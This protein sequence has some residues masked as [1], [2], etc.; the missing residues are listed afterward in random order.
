MPNLTR[1]KPELDDVPAS[2]LDEFASAR[3]TKEV[4]PPPV[5]AG[6]SSERRARSTGTKVPLFKVPDDGEEVIIRF[7]DDMPFAPLWQ[8]WITVDGGKQRAFTCIDDATTQCPL[9]SRGDKA[10]PSDWFNVVELGDTPEL[11]VWK[12]SSDPAGA[13]KDMA[14]S[15]RWSP[16]NK[17]GLYFAVSKKK[18][19]NGFPTYKLEGIKEEELVVDWG[20]KYLT[21]DQLSKFNAEKYDGSIVTVNTSSELSDLA[22]KHLTDE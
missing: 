15:K 9:C 19:A 12:A 2:G 20:A 8:H 6:W 3:V 16:I 5:Q 17:E 7:L 4:S 1:T 10:K 14:E 11:K 18:G 21:A 22:R 13:I